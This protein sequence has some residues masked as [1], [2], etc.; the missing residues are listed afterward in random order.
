[1]LARDELS[2]L[3]GMIC[4]Q[5]IEANKKQHLMISLHMIW[6]RADDDKQ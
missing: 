5:S 2:V 6:R 4:E 1:M 3:G